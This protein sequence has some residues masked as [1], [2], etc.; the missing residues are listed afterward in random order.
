VRLQSLQP[1]VC[2]SAVDG[3]NLRD[4][5]VKGGAGN[6]GALSQVK[7]RSSASCASARDEAFG[8]VPTRFAG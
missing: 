6:N 5:L 7:R 3:P 8:V 4:G 2:S 1:T